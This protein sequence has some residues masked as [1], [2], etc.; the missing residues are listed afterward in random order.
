LIAGVMRRWVVALAAG[1]ILP[2]ATPSVAADRY[3]NA[4]VDE[5]GAL[6][7][8][9]GEGRVIV[10]PKER[11]QVDYDGIAISSD[12]LSVGWLTRYPNG[13]TSYPI[14]LK[15]VV[16]SGGKRRTYG[17]NELPVWRWR[18]TASGKQIAYE[19]ETVHGGLGVHYQLREVATGRLVAEYSPKMSPD[20]QP[21]PDPR[22]PAW[23]V[24]LDE[25]R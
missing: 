24:E 2:V 11:G 21:E 6:R 13:A 8:T 18:F 25:K 5:A 1:T 3:T 14:P 22:P 15:L 9:T 16:Y 4:S 7:I 20:N 19:Q 10:F 17:G 23:V 12:G